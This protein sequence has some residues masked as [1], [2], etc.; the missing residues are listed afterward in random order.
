MPTRNIKAFILQSF[1]FK[2]S[3]RMQYQQSEIGS[4]GSENGLDFLLNHSKTENRFTQPNSS[5][6]DNRQGSMMQVVN[7]IEPAD[8]EISFVEDDD[9]EEEEEENS[10]E[11]GDEESAGGISVLSEPIAKK[12]SE[13]PPRPTPQQIPPTRPQPPPNSSFYKIP[14]GA[15]LED[16]KRD[17]LY[18][19]DRLEKK[20]YKINRRFSMA[21]NVDDMRQE[22]DRLIK[23][24]KVDA[25]IRFQQTCLMGFVSGIE[26]LNNKFDPF[27]LKLDG[28]SENMHSKMGDY[29]DT[30]EELALKYSSNRQMAPEIKLL[31]S[32]V[33]SAFMFHMTKK[34][35][36]SMPGLGEVFNENPE[37]QKQFAGAAANMMKREDASGNGS[38]LGGLA[39]MLSGMFSS[40]GNGS[41]NR[42][43]QNAQ[44]M[45]GPVV[46]PM[47]PS[48]NGPRS[49]AAEV[50][51]FMRSK[52]NVAISEDK[53]EVMSQSDASE[54]S[55]VVSLTG[56]GKRGARKRNT[57]D[58]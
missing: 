34:L 54:I 48:Q 2:F 33:G 4:T 18:Q 32:V 40:G 26:L 5:G 20:G 46:D 23:D 14:P 1:F 56:K 51:N 53:V 49:S 22:Y 8:D 45:R 24:K 17:L 3:T 7:E 21:S 12:T 19:F 58:L 39:G 55:D 27:D 38:G 31:L 37:L 41:G 30:F 47:S 25:S 15:S 57:L 44:P 50:L 28:W 43:Q 52:H 16:V 6:L 11:D 42:S 10:E 9:E 36:E 29:E 13:I 35:S